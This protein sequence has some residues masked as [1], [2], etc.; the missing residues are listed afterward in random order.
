MINRERKTDLGVRKSIWNETYSLEL[1]MSVAIPQSLFC[2]EQQHNSFDC[3]NFDL[4][5]E[6][7]LD[8]RKNS[9]NRDAP[10]AAAK[11]VVV[12]YMKSLEQIPNVRQTYV[13]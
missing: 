11:L 5:P 10:L 2:V 13:S 6:Y 12:N 9:G 3:R 4:F 1:L 7:V 8:I